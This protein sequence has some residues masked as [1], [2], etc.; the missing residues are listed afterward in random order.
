MWRESAIIVAKL[1]KGIKPPDLPVEQP[2]KFEL[3]VNLRTAKSL[4]LTI[5]VRV[6]ASDD[7]H[8]EGDA[9]FTDIEPDSA[10]AHDARSLTFQ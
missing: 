7:P 6:A 2:T 5:P 10:G 1:L 8:A 9:E 4:D 3:V